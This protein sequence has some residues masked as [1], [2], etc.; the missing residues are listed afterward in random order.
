M[1]TRN[2]ISTVFLIFAITLAYPSA[3]SATLVRIYRAEFTDWSIPSAPQQ[4]KG[5]MDDAFID[6]TEHL[7]I[8]DLDVRVVFTHSSLYDLRILLQSPGGTVITLS[9]AG[10]SAFITRGKDKRLT[11]VASAGQFYFDDQAHLPIEDGNKPY[12]G[13]L[14]PITKPYL[15]PFRPSSQLSAFN[16]QDIFG[17]WKLKIYDYIVP[18]TG[19]LDSFELIVQTP[20]PAT[21]I[22]L[23]LG[24][25]LMMIFR[26]HKRR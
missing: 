17:R 10:N 13:P 26:H 11:P 24:V 21:I 14:K 8:H 25:F 20:E 19:Q 16:E 5:W 18:D 12:H 6:I 7:T 2:S 3:V 9:E 15:G 1:K 23:M 22:L 4:S